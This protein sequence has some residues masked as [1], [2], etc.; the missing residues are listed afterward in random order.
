VTVIASDNSNPSGEL[1]LSGTLPTV[2]DGKIWLV[3]SSDVSGDD[4]MTGWNP[5][6][7][8]FESNLVT[9]P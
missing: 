6:S 5:T 2:S 9:T 4:E 1:T 3:L 7:Y 8:L